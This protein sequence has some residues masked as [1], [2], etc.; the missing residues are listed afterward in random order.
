MVALAVAAIGWYRATRPAST[1]AFDWCEF[2]GN[3]LV[4]GYEYGVGPFVSPSVDVRGDHI[5]VGLEV[6]QAGG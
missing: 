4:L 5:V 2:D 3:T 1:A 6:D